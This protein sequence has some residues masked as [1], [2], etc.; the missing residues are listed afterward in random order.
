MGGLFLVPLPSSIESERAVEAYNAHISQE[1]GLSP[2]DV[3]YY[4]KYGEL[5]IPIPDEPSPSL[6]ADNFYDSI[7]KYEVEGV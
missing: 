1:E 4:D 7:K 3:I 6:T 2:G 5:E